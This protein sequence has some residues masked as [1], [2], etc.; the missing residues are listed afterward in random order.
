MDENNGKQLLTKSGD[1]RLRRLVSAPPD[2]VFG[3]WT[4][5]EE[6]KQWWGPGN[7]RCVSA[8]IDLRVGGAYRI[9]NEMPDGTIVWIS[10][11]YQRIDRPNL[12]QFSWSTGSGSKTAERVT[13]E[14]ARHERGTLVTIMHSRIASEADH[15]SHKNGWT[16]CLDGLDRHCLGTF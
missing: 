9:G 8:E 11:R 10:G 16:G 3:L 1:L 7:V 5:P 2:R 14:F 12:L 13:V 4:R 15:E 6:L